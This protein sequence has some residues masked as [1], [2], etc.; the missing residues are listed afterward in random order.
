MKCF[1]F[2]FLSGSLLAV[3][4]ASAGNDGEGNMSVGG[5]APAVCSFRAAPRQL[6]ATNMSLAGA[7]L[8][9]GQIAVTQLID[10]S[11]A[12]LKAASIQIEILGVC[13]SAHHLT[14][15]TA[16]GGLAPEAQV[17]AADGLFSHHVNYRAEAAWGGQ[18]VTLVT[19][20]TPGKKSPTG[21]IAGAN[22]GALNLRV[23]IDGATN[24]MTSP[25]AS[26]VYFDLLILQ[27]GLPL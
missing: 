27:I 14:L 23:I 25:T 10:E 4:A 12:R 3:P 7:N 17:I 6:S 19:D 13:N 5:S 16:R 20:A 15:V 1:A 21:L 11:T 2:A 18:S 8:Q 22:D 26:G 24:D 9:S